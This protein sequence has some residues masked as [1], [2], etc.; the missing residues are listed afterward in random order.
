ML[1]MGFPGGSVVKTPSAMQEVQELWGSISG[2]ERS[3]RVGHSN[4]VRIPVF[5]PGVTHEQRS[6]V[7]YSPWSH[8]ESDIT[9]S[10]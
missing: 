3:P 6:L 9:E 10:T 4:P 5:L 2:L 8:K 7:G 1:S